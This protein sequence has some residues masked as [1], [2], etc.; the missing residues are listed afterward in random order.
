MSFLALKLNGYPIFYL[1]AF[2]PNCVPRGYMG[3]LTSF[4]WKGAGSFNASL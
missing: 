2:T 1:L 3:D 4:S